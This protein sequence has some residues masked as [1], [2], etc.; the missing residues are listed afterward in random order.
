[1]A[2]ARDPLACWSSH[3]FESVGS[4]NFFVTGDRR[5]SREIGTWNF[6]PL[7]PLRFNP[8]AN[9]A[10]TQLLSTALYNTFSFVAFFYSL[11]CYWAF[12]QLSSN[13]TSTTEWRP[14]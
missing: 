4:R 8:P 5:C 13:P 6:F 12:E 7:P 1:M 10:S 2:R 3:D 11:R 14:R 9:T